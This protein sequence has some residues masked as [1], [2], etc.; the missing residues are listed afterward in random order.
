MRYRS[1]VGRSANVCRYRRLDE[2]DCLFGLFF[3]DLDDRLFGLRLGERL[4][5][6][7]DRVERRIDF[8]GRG[9]GERRLREERFLDVDMPLHSIT[10]FWYF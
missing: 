2:I 10:M 9:L 5:G 1:S 7:G 4:F 3:G 8:L 6:L